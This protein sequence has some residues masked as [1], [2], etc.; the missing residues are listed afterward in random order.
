MKLTPSKITFNYHMSNWKSSY[1]IDNDM[2]RNIAV[3]LSF[4]FNSEITVFHRYLYNKD[5]YL[6]RLFS[7]KESNWSIIFLWY[8]LIL[9][10]LIFLYVFKVLNNAPLTWGSLGYLSKD[11][12][13]LGIDHWSVCLL[14]NKCNCWY[15]MSLII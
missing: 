5:Q 7:S 12:Y 8:S 13:M 15:K 10:F 14:T 9:D 1:D 3:T 4:L 11:M 6:L 2:A